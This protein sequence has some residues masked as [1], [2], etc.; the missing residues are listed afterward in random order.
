MKLTVDGTNRSS[1][2][3]VPNSSI[4]DRLGSELTQFKFFLEDLNNNLDLND[5]QTVLLE[6]YDGSVTGDKLFG[7][8][9]TSVDFKEIGRHRIAICTASDYGWLLKTIL[10]T[11]SYAAAQSDLTV[12][13]N[14]FTTYLPEVTTATNVVAVNASLP[15]LN[16]N[17]VTLE[18]AM[19]HIKNITG[20]D[21]YV[22]PDKDLHYYGTAAEG[23][24]YEL[25]D[26]PDDLL[27]FGYQ[28]FSYKSR[29]TEL[30]NKLLIVGGLY[31]S[32]AYTE[33][34]TGDGSQKAFQLKHIPT[35]EADITTITVD[36]AGQTL[37][38]YG[39]DG[40]LDDTSGWAN[41]ANIRYS[42]SEGGL[43]AF[44]VAPGN[45]LAIV[46][47]YKFWITLLKWVRSN[48]GYLAIGRWVE[49]ILKDESILTKDG[50]R[51]RGQQHMSDKALT[52][53]AGSCIV[54]QNGL[55]AG[56]TIRITN[57]RHSL[58]A[59]EFLIQQVNTRFISDNTTKTN[60]IAEHTLQFGVWYHDLID[61]LIENRRRQAAFT[62]VNEDEILEDSLTEENALALSD[63]ISQSTHTGSYHYG[64]TES[65][66]G[67]A[68]FTT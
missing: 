62:R 19:R 42:G 34:F 17:R 4:T 45:A 3:I 27:K 64:Q 48:S 63:S 44:K 51:Q 66:Y 47:T 59:N 32:N 35:A 38:L 52:A 2:W 37:G 36:G 10:V 46:I 12:I 43:L 68:R 15:A 40:T 13:Q 28:G 50:A 11:K 29:A 25:S 61:A 5:L 21:F 55:K 33:N 41:Q 39:I 24:P 67:Y 60:Y 22:D 30:V 1:I 23:A 54:R 26:S 49:G 56:Q 65:H 8:V 18:D 20:A 7:G 14:L 16:F 31:K 57:G 9:I 6:E 53:V 58:T